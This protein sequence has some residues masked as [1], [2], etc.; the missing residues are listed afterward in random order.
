MEERGNSGIGAKTIN[1]KFCLKRKLQHA[2]LSHKNFQTFISSVIV[3]FRKERKRCSDYI[4][5]THTTLLYLLL[6][7]TT[8]RKPG[9]LQQHWEIT[10]RKVSSSLELVS[11]ERDGTTKDW[12]T[13]PTWQSCR[14]R[15]WPT[16]Q[17]WC[18]EPPLHSI[19]SL[20][21]SILWHREGKGGN[22]MKSIVLLYW[23]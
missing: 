6:K 15:P 17:V 1:E 5:P 10:G 4:Y 18:K 3:S 13:T 20:S 19:G 7:L 16:G 9:R 23:I 8:W 12:R 2:C 22:C 14:G 21:S 11:T